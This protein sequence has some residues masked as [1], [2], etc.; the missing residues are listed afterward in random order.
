MQPSDDEGEAHQPA[1]D[2]DLSSQSRGQSPDI[3]LEQRALA[4]HGPGEFPVQIEVCNRYIFVS[5]RL[6]EMLNPNRGFS[7][8]GLTAI[9]FWKSAG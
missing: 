9:C 6:Y 3:N 4:K 8:K 1:S 5:V 7:P 2:G